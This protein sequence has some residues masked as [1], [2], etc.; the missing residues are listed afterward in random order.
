MSASGSRHGSAVSRSSAAPSRQGSAA[1]K[2]NEAPPPRISSAASRTASAK[3]MGTKVIIIG[4]GIAGLSAATKLLESGVN[5]LIVIEA[6]DRTGGRLNTIPF[7][8]YS[9]LNKTFFY[10]VLKIILT[11]NRG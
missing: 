3:T 1:S 8:K 4:A 2:R 6:R 11:A 9:L 7:R 5:E 10:L